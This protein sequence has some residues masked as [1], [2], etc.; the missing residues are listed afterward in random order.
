MN[1]SLKSFCL[2]A[3]FFLPIF[4]IRAQENNALEILRADS[5]KGAMGF[6]R[7]LGSVRMKNQ[8]T[9]IECDSAHF[10]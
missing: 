6:E 8:S 4:M 7:L 9:L 3:F 5:L 1:S 10:F 2:I